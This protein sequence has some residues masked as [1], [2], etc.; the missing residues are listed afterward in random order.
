MADYSKIRQTKRYRLAKERIRKLLKTDKVESVSGTS[1]I[2]GKGSHITI[3]LRNGKEITYKGPI[4]SPLYHFIW[5]KRYFKDE[6]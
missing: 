6:M 1:T 2:S 3:H 5:K 4:A